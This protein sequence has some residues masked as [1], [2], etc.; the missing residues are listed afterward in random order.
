MMWPVGDDPR[1]RAVGAA[2]G[3]VGPAVFLAGWAVVGAATAGYSARHQPIS[4]LARIGAPHRL[5]MTAALFV[6]GLCL[7]GFAPVLGRALGRGLLT[8]G[9]A[10]IGITALG[11]AAF[12]LTRVAHSTGDT[13]H[14]TFAVTGYLAAAAT[15]LI[16]GTAQWARGERGWAAGSLVAAG[17][18]AVALTVAVAWANP[19]LAQ[20]LGLTVTDLWLM[21]MAARVLWSGPLAPGPRDAAVRVR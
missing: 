7:L 3:L 18:A 1:W 12:P 8:A 9:V 11:V 13:V 21:V 14:A 15:P 6:Y 4:D 5:A 2:C 10:L 17:V 16:G 19:G 20:R